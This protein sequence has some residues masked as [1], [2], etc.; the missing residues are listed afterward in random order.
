M[1]WDLARRLSKGVVVSAVIGAA[2]VAAP[3]AWAVA[4]SAAKVNA[5]AT[6]KCTDTWKTAASGL[7]SDAADWSTGDVPSST[8]V[9][10]I[11]KTSKSYTV[12]L[13]NS[14]SVKS[15]VLG[16]SSGATK[17]TVLFQATPTIGDADLT[18][19]KVFDIEKT[20]IFQMAD[21]GGGNDFLRN[22]TVDN[23]GTF[24]TTRGKGWSREIYAG[25]V[26]EP[27]GTVDIAATSIADGGGAT[28]M[29]N[30]S[31]TNEGTFDVGATS[32]FDYE[33]GTNF[34][35]VLSA[36]TVNVATNS[37][38]SGI[39]EINGT[40]LT[41]SGSTET[42][43]P[44]QLNGP[45][46]T[47]S[48]GK[49]SY[50][51]FNGDSISGT[52]PKGQSITVTGNGDQDVRLAINGTVTNKGTLILTSGSSLDS[53][54]GGN[55]WISPGS[56]VPNFVNDGTFEL[57]PGIGWS[58]YLNVPVTN[59]TKGTINVQGVDNDSENSDITNDGTFDMGANAIINLNG[60]SYGDASFTEG[61]TA[62][63][64]VTVDGSGSSEILQGGC[65]AGGCQTEGIVVAGTLVVTTVGSPADGGWTIADTQQ[66]SAQGSFTTITP[67]GY[68]VTMNQPSVGDISLAYGG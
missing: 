12:T 43:A 59:G 1:N 19:T 58:R 13:E 45:A 18:L 14:Y 21:K 28:Y 20:G 61:G 63:L 53:T 50:N 68:G 4:P 29:S 39:L 32:E 44:V 35:V 38:S 56:G 41:L 11:N 55:S 33:G 9:A 64:G 6:P 30:G 54:D 27:G 2:S 22:G 15:L 57:L 36:G 40:N 7:W 48:A 37:T 25:I 60:T 51:L 52:I 34:N 46:I 24:K 26:N 5:A 62:T 42:G 17:Q 49:G 8:D 31:L 23:Y 16:A 65:S 47:D 10:C 66:T 3:A 67:A